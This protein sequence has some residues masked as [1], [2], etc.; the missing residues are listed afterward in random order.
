MSELTP[1]QIEALNRAI[2]EWEG[3]IDISNGANVTYPYERNGKYSKK[4]DYTRDLNLIVAVVQGWC[5]GTK[6]DVPLYP[7]F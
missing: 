7:L 2:A 4:L 5:E 3:W 6:V 1:E